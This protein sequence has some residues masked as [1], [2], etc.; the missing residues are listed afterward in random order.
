MAEDAQAKV[1]VRA[2]MDVVGG[3]HFWESVEEEEM[4]MLVVMVEAEL[5]VLTG[6]ELAV[7]MEV[8]AR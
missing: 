7:G 1:V 8:A 6:A 5:E 2:V 4:A 3:C